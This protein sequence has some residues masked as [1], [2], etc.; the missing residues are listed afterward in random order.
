M[1]ILKLFNLI[2]QMNHV[3]ILLIIKMNL[4]KNILFIY[5]ILELEKHLKMN[6]QFGMI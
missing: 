4:V 1:N 2:L 3:L 5:P 6:N